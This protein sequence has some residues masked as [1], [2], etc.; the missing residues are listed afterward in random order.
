MW[1]DLKHEY[2]EGILSISMEC[3][4]LPKLRE[5]FMVQIV[6][7]STIVPQKRVSDY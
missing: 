2:K 3:L 6:N 4:Y 7:T 5:N 1:H